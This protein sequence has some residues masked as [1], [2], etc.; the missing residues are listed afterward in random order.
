MTKESAAIQKTIKAF[1]KA[2][3]NQKLPVAA[4]RKNFD[5]LLGNPILPNNI[6]REEI[7][8]N[9]IQTDILIP[10]LAVENFTILYAHGGGFITGSRYAYRNFCSSLAHET[11]CRLILPEYQ[12]APEHPYPT[13]L[14]NLYSVFSYLIKNN[15]SP[16]SVIFAGDGAGANLVLALIH[17]LKSKNLKI[18]AALILFS[19]WTDISN[20]NRKKN[21]KSAD[22]VFTNEILT[23]QALQYT[24]ESNFTNQYVSP[25]AG[26][27]TDF[28][29]M[30]IQCGS[31]D[32]L[33]E[34]TMKLGE[35]AAECGVDATTDIRSGMW[36][37][38]QA[39]D[40]VTPEARLAV[41]D[42]GEWVRKLQKR[43]LMD[44]GNQEN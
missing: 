43:I 30:Y 8:I 19:P 37:L 23:G 3:Y 13:A 26:D 7:S 2:V 27:L 14:E 29:P 6:D 42:T 15:V 41:K 31:C 36:H 4:I 9:K 16:G 18:P 20:T 44:D 35:K 28:P 34:D 21:K 5:A 32:L 12:L 25:I 40:S 1:R 24:F 11:A 39:F 22:P 17:Y 33:L 38:F 10:E